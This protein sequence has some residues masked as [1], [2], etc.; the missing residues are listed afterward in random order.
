M[1]F[2]I[3]LTPVDRCV[4]IYGPKKN[5]MPARMRW[6]HPD[7]AASFAQIADVV[8]VSDMFRSP[9]SSLQAVREGRGAA[10]PG[11][12]SH[13]YGRAFDVAV[14]ASMKLTGCATKA[15]FDAFMASHGWH[16]WRQD[17]KSGSECWHYFYAASG[18]YYVNGNGVHW[19]SATMFKEY[20]V[21]LT[22]T[23]RQ[24]ALRSLGF[25]GGAIDG[26]FGDLSSTALGAFRNAWGSGDDRT[27]AY[28]AWHKF[29]GVWAP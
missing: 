2:N 10:A 22:A 18:F 20:P 17:G 4:G 8:V 26:K 9:D 11:R 15:E 28:V 16:C 6:L 13:N 12:S 24:C 19:W 3:K 14:A 23:E 27:L 1:M 21:A 25:Y 29:A 7:A 5:E